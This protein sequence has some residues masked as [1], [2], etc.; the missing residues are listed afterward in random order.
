MAQNEEALGAA[1][2]LLGYGKLLGSYPMTRELSASF[3]AVLD[4]YTE[5][6]EKTA[7]AIENNPDEFDQWN[8]LD[9]LNREYE[10]KVFD[11]A[12]ASLDPLDDDAQAQA[13]TAA[14][15]DGTA[16]GATTDKGSE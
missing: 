16:P 3:D 5:L 11:E 9:E 15:I 6:T 12:L 8:T 13:L 10:Q 14:A 7:T 4:L 1:Q 2:E